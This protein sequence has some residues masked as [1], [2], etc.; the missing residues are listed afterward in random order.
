LADSRT[1]IFI[2]FCFH[3]TLRAGRYR[4]CAK[5]FVFPRIIE[6]GYDGVVTMLAGKR[7]VFWAFRC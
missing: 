3:G 6:N 1:E 4:S 7:M 2:F 5:D